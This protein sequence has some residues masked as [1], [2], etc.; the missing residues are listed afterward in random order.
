[1]TANRRR[2]LTSATALAGALLVAGGT[3]QAQDAGAF[4]DSVARQ[5]LDRLK[6]GASDAERSN[7]L[8]TVLRTNFDLPSMGR[9]ALGQY[10]TKATPEQQQRYLAAVEHAE[11]RAYSD[12]LKQYGGQTLK[13]NKVTPGPG[14][15][16]LVDSAILQPGGGQV[17]RLV[18]EVHNRG[19]KPL[20]T[21]VSIEG[22]SMV[23]TRRSDFT[24]Y[25]SRNGGTVEPLI[26]E[27]E[28][29]AK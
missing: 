18:W 16:Q 1:M 26:V 14:G 5:V 4:V 24:A 29:R 8:R 20:V 12:R 10:W 15:A 7:L 6:Q 11:V 2:F 9:A 21:D 3:A 28:R 25:I 17:V 13:V 27:L 22:V 19:G 23:L